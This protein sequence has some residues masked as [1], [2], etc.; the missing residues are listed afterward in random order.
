MVGNVLLI[1]DI[2]MHW[3]LS[4]YHNYIEDI[5]LRNVLLVPKIEILCS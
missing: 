1:V 2:F 4:N 3:V 5:F